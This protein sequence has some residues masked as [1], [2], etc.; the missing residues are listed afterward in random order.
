MV[1]A[2]QA[3][4][5][6]RQVARRWGVS[7]ATVQLWV[8]RARGQELDR[9]DWQ[10]RSSRPHGT[11][12]TPRSVEDLVLE[13]RQHLKD[14]SALGECGAVAIHVELLNRAHP[15]VPSLRTIGRILDRRGALDGRRRVRRPPPPLGWYLPAVERGQAEVDS[16]DIIEGLAIRRGPHVEILNAIS[17]HGG[18]MQSWAMPLVSARA[19]V[20]A[21]LEHW[22]AVGLPAYAQ[23]DNDTIFQG[24]H[25]HPDSI[26]RVMRLCLSLG[27][28]PVFAPPREPGFQA[29]IE[30]FNGRWQTKVWIRF[31][32]ESL[33][34]L[35][36][37]SARYVAAA[38]QRSASRIEAAPERR[39]LPLTWQL[40]LQ[41]HPRGV[42]IYVRR[43]TERGAVNVLGHTF[44]VDPMWASRLVRCE[45][46]LDAQRLRCYAL[47]RRAP[48]DQPLLAELPYA[49]PRRRFHDQP[50]RPG[51]RH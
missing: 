20:E 25:Q 48:H 40:D 23:F 4:S 39:P 44:A 34:A 21:L 3:G 38:R 46:D 10:D 5:G 27:V 31:E 12:R 35:Q 15:A 1:A 49:V 30:A 47:R 16:F 24:A 41:A 42:L 50:E 14:V 29:A 36:G 8:G 37:R 2:V 32:H 43:T 9:V 45:F 13:V 28:V 17:L 22:R 18:L 7:L 33:V 19:A 51:T 6:L 26:G 11:R